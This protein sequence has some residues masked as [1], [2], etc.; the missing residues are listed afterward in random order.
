MPVVLVC[1]K[2][3]VSATELQWSTGPPYV[4]QP[5]RE[6]RRPRCDCLVNAGDNKENATDDNQGDSPRG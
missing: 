2:Y 6:D 1:G 3:R 5:G 4:E